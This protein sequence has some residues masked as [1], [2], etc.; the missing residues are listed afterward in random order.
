HAH[1]QGYADLN[2]MIP[3]LATDVT[4]TKGTYYADEGDFASVGSVHVRYRDT[5]EDRVGLTAGSFDFQRLLTAGSTPVAAGHLLGALELQ[6]YDGPWVDPEDQRKVNAVLRYS[7]GS[8]RDGFSVTAM[9]YRGLWNSTTDQPER[10]IASGLIGRF[11][12][13]DPSD[14]GEAQ[15]ESLSAEYGAPLAGGRLAASAYAIGN[16]LTLWNDFTHFLVDPVHGDQ[17]AQ[18]ED[19]ATLGADASYTWAQSV[20]GVQTVFAV[21]W[22]TRHDTVDVWRLPTQDRVLLTPAQLAAVDSPPGFSETDEVHLTSLAGYFEATTYWT[23]WMRS[24]LGFRED[25]LHGLDS[26]THSGEAAAQI[27]Q[28]KANLIFTPLP[29]TELY[30]SWGRGFHSDDLRGVTQAQSAGMR[31]APLIASQAGEEIGIRQQFMRS[32]TATLALYALDAQSETTYDPDVGQDVAGPASRRYGAELNATW[33]VTRWLEAYG[34][35]SA[36]HARFRTPYDD[37]TGHI[38]EY[39]P[40]AP[41][42]AGSLDLYVKHL[43]RWS[44]GLEYRYVGAFPL[45]SDDAIQGHGY[46]EWNGDVRYDAPRGWTLGLALFNLLDVRTDAA[47]FW[48]VDRLQGEPPD[49]VADVHVHPLE[50]RAVRFTVT[51]HFD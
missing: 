20:A 26:G 12:S 41:F 31:G 32:F 25:Y 6:H 45:S 18:H 23:A 46:R 7:G 48:Y 3:E 42:A 39:L 1:G 50:P 37:G 13:L 2:F 19:R 44:G 30:L 10:A 17:E 14:G 11:G 24:V 35:Y 16:R 5:I 38:G 29:T 4:Y 21:G 49:G 28:P 47:E 33:Q 34:T 36:N 15:R 9:Y 27:A 22:H 40:N 43:G 51:K 8:A